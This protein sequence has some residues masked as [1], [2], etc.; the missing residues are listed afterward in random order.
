MSGT[1]PQ[2]DVPTPGAGLDSL[3]PERAPS[4]IRDPG[5]IHYFLFA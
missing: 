5:L 3:S 1:D 4:L 2:A